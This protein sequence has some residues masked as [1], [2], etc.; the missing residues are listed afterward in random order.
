MNFLQGTKYTEPVVEPKVVSAQKKTAIKAK[1]KLLV[2]KT[3]DK[4]MSKGEIVKALDAEYLAAGEHIH[5]SV[6]KEC[7][8][9]VYAEYNP[10]KKTVKEPEVT[11]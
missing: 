6:F 4:R 3:S 5:D 8:N 9:D 2:P 11:E 7:F 1:I 10:P